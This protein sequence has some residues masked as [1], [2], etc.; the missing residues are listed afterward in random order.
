MGDIG[1]LVSG[2]RRPGRGVCR[3]QH[4]QRWRR[5]LAWRGTP[6]RHAAPRCR[7]CGHRR[8]AP[9]GRRRVGVRGDWV[10][11]HRCRDAGRRLGGVARRRGAGRS[12][13]HPVRGRG[14]LIFF[15]PAALPQFPC[16]PPLAVPARS[17]RCLCTALETLFAESPAPARV[18][19]CSPG[20]SARMPTG[21]S[22][23]A[24]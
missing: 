5:P 16:P 21:N 19:L 14:A 15:P 11:E 3:P 8:G 24:R 17:R 4:R 18:C 22:R 6:G 1:W 12:E 9:S 7:R 2:A 10:G 13:L 23:Y 20:A